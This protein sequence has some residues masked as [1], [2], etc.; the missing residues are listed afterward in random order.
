MQGTIDRLRPEYAA[1]QQRIQQVL[2]TDGFAAA[3]K[4]QRQLRERYEAELARPEPQPQGPAPDRSLP[5]AIRR[6]YG[7]QGVLGELTGFGLDALLTKLGSAF[8]P[9]PKGGWEGVELR[10]GSAAAGLELAVEAYNAMPTDDRIQI[11]GQIVDRAA[12]EDR[13]LGG[14][15]D[16]SAYLAKNPT[17]AIN[18][19]VEMI[20]PALPGAVGGGL[21]ARPVARKIA[22]EAAKTTAEKTAGEAAKTTAG[23]TLAGQVA[24]QNTLRGLA[25]TGT[26]HAGVTGGGTFTGA[27]ALEFASRLDANGGDIDEAAQYAL[28]KAS[29]EGAVN[30]PFGFA[31]GMIPV[32]GTPAWTHFVRRLEQALIQ[33]T[34]GATGAGVASLSVGE[35][36]SPGELF[37]EFFFEAATGPVDAALGALTNQDL[38][39]KINRQEKAIADA[40]A[41]SEQLDAVMEAANR[42]LTRQRS[43]ATFA[44]LVQQAAESGGTAPTEL[45]IDARTLVEALEQSGMSREQLEQALPSVAENLEVAV[46]LETDVVIPIGEATA[47]LAGTDL[48]QVLAQNARTRE[49]GLSL[50]EAEAQDAELLQ[51]FEADAAKVFAE[52]SDRQAWEEDA[53][54]VFDALTTELGNAGRFA[55][56]VNRA[57]ATLLRNF[58]AT[59]ASRLGTTPSELYARFPLR[60]SSRAPGQQTPVFDQYAS[61]V[62]P[63]ARP[64]ELTVEGVHFSAVRREVL[65]GSFY[66]TG[67]RGAEARRLADLPED[68]PLRRRVYAYVDEGTGVRPEQGVGSTAHAVTLQNIYDPGRD[69]LGIWTGD[70]N[71]NEQ[72][73]LDAGFDGYYVPGVMAAGQGRTQGAVV[74][75][76]DAAQA[77]PTREYT[78][79]GVTGAQVQENPVRDALEALD[80]DYSFSNGMMTPQRLGE[81]VQRARPDLYEILEP[82]G[83]FEGETKAYRADIISA[84]RDSD[85]FNQSLSTRLP[86]AV[87]AT[88]DPLNAVLNITFD[89][90]LSDTKTLA[91]NMAAINATPNMRKLTGKGAKDPAKQAEA[92]IEHVKGNLLWLHDHMPQEMRERAKL[93]YDGGR[94]T[95]EHWSRRYGTSQMQGAAVIAVMSPQNGWF[96]NVSQAERVMD[97]V[98]GARDVRW[99]DAMTAEAERIS[100]E[101]GLDANMQA[102]QG[103]TL[104]ELLDTPEVAARWIRVYDQ[105]HNNR[106]YRA[107]TPEGGAADYVKTGAGN[108]ATMMWKSYVTIAKAVSVLVDGRAENVHY[109]LGKE[110]KV[111]NFYNNLLE[112][113]SELGFATIDTHAVAA[114]ML[115]PLA[116]SDTE[117]LQAFGGTGAASSSVTG[118]RGTYPIYL[119]AYRRAAEERGLQA[120]EMQSITWEAVRG[121]FEA[122][123]KSGL[124]K[125][126]NAIWERYKS[127]E[128]EQEQ[129][130]AEILELAGDI[131]PPSWTAVE[132]NDQP[133]RTYEGPIQAVMDERGEVAA[134]EN[135]TTVVFEVAPDPND[136][137]LTARWNALDDA[138]RLRLSVAVAQDVVPKVLKEFSTDGEFSVQLG[139]YLGATNPSLTLRLEHPELAVQISKAL[140]HI[141]SQD[142]MVVV[143]PVAIAGADPT[144]S[145]TM[146][147]PD[148][149]GAAEVEALYDRLWELEDNGEKLVGGHT[150]ADGQMA[151][152]NFTDLDTAELARRI[153]EHLGGAFEVAI[154]E[155]FAAFPQREDYGYGSNR[156]EGATAPTQPSLQTRIDNVRTEAG[157]L[158]EAGLAELERAETSS[159][160]RQDVLYQGGITDGQ[161]PAAGN[162]AGR[163]A[164]RDLAP[165]AGAPSVQGFNGP[166][167]R[168]VAVAEQYAASIGIELKRQ[169]EYVDVDPQRAARIAE[170]YEAMEHAPQ[171]PV[172]REAYENLIQQT[173]AQYQALVDAGY[174]FWFMDMGREDNQQYASSPW[175]AMRDIRANQSMGVFP[176]SDGFGSSDLDVNDNPLL[177]DTGLQWPVGAPDGPLAP[178]LAN[179]LFR[180]VHDAFGHGLEGAGFRAR[181]EENAWQAHVRLFTGSAVGAITS[182]TRGQNSWLNYGPYGEQNRTAKVEDTVFADQKTGLM[183]EWTWTEGRVADEAEQGDVLN[184]SAQ[185]DTE[186]FR[187]WFGDSK[188][189]DENGQPL[190]VYHGTA[191]DFDAFSGSAQGDNFGDYEGAFPRDGFWFT[192]SPSNAFWYSNVS[193]N[194]LEGER[195]GGGQ[196]TV[197][198]YLSIKNPFRY[199]A[200]MFA[201]EGEAGIPSQY[202]LEQ[203][204]YDGLIVEV[205]SDEDVDTPE[206]DAM[207]AKY[208]PTLGAPIGW[209]ADLRAEYERLLDVPPAIQYTH[210]VA[211]RPEQIKSA[212]GNDG[213]FDPADPNI[214][215]QQPQASGARAS[216]NPA[217]MEISLLEKADLSS[218]LHEAGHFF[219]EMLGNLAAQPDVPQALRD[220][221]QVL[222]DHVGY[223][224]TIED[225]V[226]LSVSERREAHETIAESFEQYLFTGKAPTAEMQP[227]FRRFKSWMVSVYRSLQ[228]FLAGNE[229][230]SLS[231][232]VSG[233]FDRLIATEEEIKAAQA[234]RD[235]QPLFETAE[236]AGLAPE[237]WEAYQANIEQHQAEALEELQSRSL[238]DMKWLDNA[239]SRKLR[240]L[241][242]EAAARR[243]AM[244]DE[245]TAEIEAEPVYAAMEFLKHGRLQADD[246]DI[247]IAENKAHKLNIDAV[248]ALFPEGELGDNTA[249]KK[250][251]Y[252][253]YGM[254]SKEGLPPD[255]VAEMFGFNSGRDLVTS[256]LNVEPK[257]QAINGLTDQRMLE[258]YGDLS[259]PA[260]MREAANEA[261]ANEAR[262]RMVATELKAVAKLTGSPSALA[263]AARQAA[264]EIVAARKV[265]NLRPDLAAAAAQRARK[266]AEKAMAAGDT[267]GAA[268]A[269]RTEI[270]N[271]QLER[272]ERN[273]RAEHDKALRGFQKINK[274][275]NERLAKSRDVDLVNAA[276]AVLARYGLAPRGAAVNAQNYMQLLETYDGSLSEDLR[277]MLQGLP[278]TMDFRDMTVE[279]FNGMRDIVNG[280]YFLSKRT[281]QMEIDGQ[282]VELDAVADEIVDGILERT[283]GELPPLP[284]YTN[285]TTRADEWKVGLLGA[286][287]SLM[288]VEAW[289]DA[290][291]APFK[292]YIWQPVSE[293]ITRTKVK[294]NEMVKQYL[295]LLKG[296]E[297][298]L[299]YDKINAPELGSAGFTFNAGKTELLHAVLHAGNQSNLKKLLLGRGWGTLREDGSLDTSRWDAFMAR[300]FAEGT[301][302]QA[303]MDFVQGVW[304]LLETIKVDAQ[305]AHKE[306]Y[307]YYFSEI[308]ADPVQTPWGEYRGGYVPAIADTLSS[309][310]AAQKREQEELLH[311]G[312]SFMFPTTGKGFTQSR[313]E[314]NRPL[315]LDLRAIGMHIDK[316]A[317]FAYI[318]PAVRDVGRLLMNRRVARAMNGYDQGL[319]SSM[320]NPWLQRSARQSVNAPGKNPK[321]DKFFNELRGRA[322]M[323]LMFGNV[324]NTMQQITGFSLAAL[325]VPAHRLLRANARY[326]YNHFEVV[327]NARTLSPWLADRMD[328]YSF[329]MMG[330]I[331]KILLDPNPVK[332]A[333]QY[334]KRNAYFMQQ[335]IQNVLDIIVWTGAYDHAV[336]KGSSQKDAVRYADETV[337]M[338]QGSFAPEDISAFEVQSP[339]VRLFTQF[340]GYFNM[341]GNLLGAEGSKALRD[342][343]FVKASPRLLFLWFVGMAIPAFVAELI[344]AGA[345]DEEDDEDGDGLLDEWLAMFFGSQ[346][347]SVAA[348]VP[349]AGQISVLA[350]N[351]M[352]DKVYNDRL[353]ISPSVSLIESA[354]YGGTAMLSGEMFDGD[355]SKKEMRSALILTGMAFGVPVGPLMRAGSFA[356][357]EAEGR[358]EADGPV[359]YGTGLLLGR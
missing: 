170:A 67:A 62:T 201:E 269:K 125:K 40:R 165:L 278:P 127:G 329:E 128:I 23:T 20:G 242:R 228:D 136:A 199:T 335:G 330:Q 253:K 265:R 169:A 134:Q 149:M 90:A 114:A 280:L 46:G 18:F 167:P 105:T 126:A 81:H 153:D 293:A 171:D 77:I 203:Q 51:Q 38:L 42:S 152:L 53:K 10:S 341:W 317:R 7:A 121:L 254:L 65:D 212:I 47:A 202:E 160:G 337:R 343:G 99:D 113:H 122:A 214:L 257:A 163:P 264:E 318:E 297:K 120:R 146:S 213:N 119:E 256:I 56:D 17:A 308:T 357:D 36:V 276:R 88:E 94:K 72:A 285:T 340:Y 133:G 48:E 9:E 25:A 29:V 206:A 14:I 58:Y 205:T 284:G 100:G 316:V 15:G 138:A 89:V 245:I 1:E 223:K 68:S 347:K 237:D 168:L 83:L 216:F 92:F 91:K 147:L 207:G 131:T 33:G 4:L 227:L 305:A 288:R 296:I 85:V 334:L 345:P 190:V 108:D 115:R 314:Y 63:G 34:G 32:V 315:A 252:G 273:A 28:K 283:D 266:A 271:V 218:F 219:F 231:P 352:D 344:A 350:S 302:T 59:T 12:E 358:K 35:A 336:A 148:G 295:D 175:N 76:G 290:M 310:D 342:A 178:V 247:Q 208:T 19:I 224:G 332:Q 39:A 64:G 229:R 277:S 31:A 186:A 6:Y 164:G 226:K 211:F 319:I 157:Q 279:Q 238:R 313:V 173:M 117:V 331:D 187:N 307:G 79:G 151:I 194:G 141:L 116:S 135:D 181:G 286:K 86:T 179:D 239:R 230:A 95:I 225:W 49:D 41:A 50:A 172:V 102:A 132:F 320:L 312:N 192:D 209:P 282:K 355:L 103:K 204:G 104:G 144:G 74:V 197:P 80:N 110:H 44:Q 233:V 210:Y 250:L 272:A 326:I 154:D 191:R 159:A 11:A 3:S 234:V 107:L 2:R 259:S 324:V 258:R 255:V 45:F 184:Q 60:V 66:G 166:D 359:E 292:K 300:M 325:K 137:E 328:N 244:R 304:D 338:T 323:V 221:M 193:A 87:R 145:V 155:V 260:A 268:A 174:R 21:V 220:D 262:A 188:V 249:W 8:L 321:V 217:N 162:G 240:E 156:P 294:R 177:A 235:F 142:S 16:A 69:P 195:A 311:A 98:F 118:L 215:H 306:M 143:S 183:P 123:K 182:E 106:A 281:K 349:V 180:A 339:F 289:A 22:G 55:S 287:A 222:L 261:L 198:A 61:S 301:I 322:G 54:Q 70:A 333:G 37:L 140:G 112:P 161:D 43:P 303:D 5:A 196:R 52:Q 246:E 101:G 57:Y 13:L 24:R 27:L 327:E 275:T 353:N 109:Q 73:V 263:R 96:A 189:V 130:Q 251:G 111:R 176:T 348:M 274:G 298:G 309:P 93:W 236:A 158:L 354:V 346:A 97:L 129:A 270:L 232:E 351:Y 71:A 185:T 82:T 241:Q 78:P 150:T 291:G 30:A 75:L 200:E 299:T 267:A 356:I 243:K 84:A 124:K 26:V 139:G 248:A